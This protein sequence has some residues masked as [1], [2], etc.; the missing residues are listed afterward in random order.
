VP[1]CSWI[2]LAPA[3]RGRAL[4][5]EVQSR[6]GGGS[7]R[8]VQWSRG[9]STTSQITAARAGVS[10]G[11]SG[12]RRLKALACGCVVFSELNMPWLDSLIPPCSAI[13]IGCGTLKPI[14]S[15]S[16][17]RGRPRRLAFAAAG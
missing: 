7:C 5:V 17:G 2:R 10:R 13:Q 9:A 11:V 1:N 12:C 16:S 8:A 14:W 6:L 4:R 3:L 15:G